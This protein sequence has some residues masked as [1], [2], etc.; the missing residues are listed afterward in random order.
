MMHRQIAGTALLASSLFLF[1]H[2]LVEVNY[3]LHLPPS[4]AYTKQ[5]FATENM[6]VFKSDIQARQITIKA[7]IIMIC[8][9]LSHKRS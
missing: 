3:Y 4:M 9:S 1:E 8:N 2:L 7:I 6:Y 5:K